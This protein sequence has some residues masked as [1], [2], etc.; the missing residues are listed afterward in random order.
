MSR[1]TDVLAARG[2]VTRTCCH[3][4]SMFSIFVSSSDSLG[5]KGFIFIFTAIKVA[6]LNKIFSKS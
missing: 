6:K 5:A 2:G 3:I 1:L 4:I